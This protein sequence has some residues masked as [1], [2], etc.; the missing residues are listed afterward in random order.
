MT[1]PPW[2]TTLS[3][4][5]QSLGYRREFHTKQ[6]SLWCKRSQQ[7]TGTKTV[8]NGTLPAHHPA[9]VVENVR[10]PCS[11]SKG[12]GGY[13]PRPKFFSLL[14][15]QQPYRVQHGTAGN[16]KYQGMDLV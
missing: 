8:K 6:Q 15:I 1:D 9:T 11:S 4:Y 10:K 13:T 2:G 12:D 7:G 5:A 3:G 16:Q 14:L